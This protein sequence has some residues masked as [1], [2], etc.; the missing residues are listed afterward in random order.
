M[1]NSC[2]WTLAGFYVQKSNVSTYIG[3]NNNFSPSQAIYLSRQWIINE[4]ISI[5]IPVENKY[6][7]KS[8]KENTA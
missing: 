2:L 3:I 7:L 4:L 6:I 5:L 8:M 1:V